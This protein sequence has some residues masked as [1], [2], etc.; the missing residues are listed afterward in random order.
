MV[1]VCLNQS[2]GSG[3]LLQHRVW[4]GGGRR[5]GKER[6]AAAILGRCCPE[7]PH[8]AERRRGQVAGGRG[9]GCKA[10]TGKSGGEGRGQEAEQ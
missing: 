8:G 5:K 2:S 1:V 9:G 7:T 10:G 4:G 3:I 6:V